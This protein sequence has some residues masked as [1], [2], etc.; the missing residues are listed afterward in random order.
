[1][2]ASEARDR[3]AG[4]GEV[5]YAATR[6]PRAVWWSAGLGMGLANAVRHRLR[7]YRTPRPFGADEV[8]R[9]VA[10]VTGV[11][12]RWARDG[13]LDFTGRRVL[14]LGPGPD[15]GTGAIML[16]R[17]AESYTAADLF[18]LASDTAPAFYEALG[19]CLG[20]PV[21][22]DRLDYR[23][24]AF[25][26]M[27]GVAGPFD[28][29]VSNA[30]LEHFDDVPA[31]FARLAEL[32]APGGVMCHHIDGMTHMR[33]IRSRDP[34]NMLRYPAPLYRAMSF[35]GVPNRLR[36]RDFLD[37]AA[38]TGW[39]ARVVPGLVAPTAY[40]ESARPGLARPYRTRDA[41]DLALLTF[42]LL[43]RRPDQRPNQGA[44][45]T[46]RRSSTR[47]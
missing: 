22:R 18:P 12:E 39:N 46:G 35:P 16:A 19:A 11:V 20:R 34:L 14:E 8:G 36:A 41:D 17:G 25:P 2:T 5:T 26:G 3:A 10:Y 31:T 15:L 1:M 27:P 6:H 43:A 21:E 42:T 4:P 9:G 28:L 38:A 24:T 13:D 7:G 37:A 40:V 33:G 32:V 23:V 29:V 44:R 45:A 47:E 30:A